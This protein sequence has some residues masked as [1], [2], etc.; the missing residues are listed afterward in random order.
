MLT[1]P[2][3]RTKV[4]QSNHAKRLPP[5][6]VCQTRYE[7]R[8]RKQHHYCPANHHVAALTTSVTNCASVGDRFLKPATTHLT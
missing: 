7:S 8:K 3:P 1:L 6:D 4:D 5:K 2:A